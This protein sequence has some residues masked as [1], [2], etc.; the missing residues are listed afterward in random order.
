MQVKHYE[1]GLPCEAIEIIESVVV[2]A[3]CLNE[4]QKYNVGNALKYLLR[5]GKKGDAS[6]AA[7]DLYKTLDYVHRAYFGCWFGED[8]SKPKE[9]KSGR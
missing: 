9:K 7:K 2:N 6:D 1:D 5:L 3:K 8:L 4:D